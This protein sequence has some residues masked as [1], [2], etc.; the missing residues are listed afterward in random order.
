L[1]FLHG[2][3][4][5]FLSYFVRNAAIRLRQIVFLEKVFRTFSADQ[6]IK[7]ILV[8]KERGN[9]AGIIDR[10][11]FNDWIGLKV[12][13]GGFME[14]NLSSCPGGFKMS[15]IFEVTAEDLQRLA[16]KQLGRKLTEEEMRYVSR[17]LTE[18]LLSA[19]ELRAKRAME[20]MNVLDGKKRKSRI[21]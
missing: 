20:F 17:S 12:K 19:F 1:R 9:V 4:L 6:G 8:E 16:R 5:V 14:K 10:N 13:Y 2:L 18:E 7:Y 3:W 11:V 15:V 21:F